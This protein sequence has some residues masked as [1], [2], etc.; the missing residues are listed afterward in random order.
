V[1]ATH[2]RYGALPRAIGGLL[3]ATN[4]YQFISPLPV[5]DLSAAGKLRALAVT[6]PSRLPVLSDVPPV[7][8]AGFPDLIIEDWFG[9]LVKAG[10]P[11]EIVIRL[12][13]AIHQALGHPR[14]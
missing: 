9:F 11:H 12:D 14:V 6:A 7:G 10:T 13:E 5:V 3:N 4:H 1:R 8:E 2:V